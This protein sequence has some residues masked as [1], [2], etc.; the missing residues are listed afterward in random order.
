MEL[1][2]EWAGGWAEVEPTGEWAAGEYSGM[3]PTGVWARGVWDALH[4]QGSTATLRACAECRAAGG[5]AAILP[6]GALCVLLFLYIKMRQ[7]LVPQDAC[8]SCCSPVPRVIPEVLS[9]R[10]FDWVAIT[11][12]EAASVFLEAWE[13][14]GKPKVMGRGG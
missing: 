1:T 9:S 8:M 6:R 12:P 13:E 7:P 2:G 14:A 10:S 11:S 5:R 3:D 4:R